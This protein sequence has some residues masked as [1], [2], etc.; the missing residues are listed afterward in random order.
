M[1]FVTIQT[2]DQENHNS[3]ERFQGFDHSM[4]AGIKQKNDSTQRIQLLEK[5]LDEAAV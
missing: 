2:G 3:F 4:N 5:R 1:T